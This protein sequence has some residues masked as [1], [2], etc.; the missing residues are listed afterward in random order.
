MTL[1]VIYVVEWR[2]ED[3]GRFGR[4]DSIS[5][6]TLADVTASADNLGVFIGYGQSNSDCCGSSGYVLSHPTNL[7]QFSIGEH[8]SNQTWRYREPMLGAFCGG[9]CPYGPI[10]DELITNGSYAQV[11]FATAGMPG[12]SIDMLNRNH[13]ASHTYFEYLVQT[14]RA[15]FR[16]YGKIDGILFHQ[17]ESDV[18]RSSAYEASFRTL[19]T[20]LENALQ[21]L[22]DNGHEIVVFVSRASYCAGN[23]DADLVD[24]Q[25][26]LPSV[27]DGAATGPNTDEL[28]G[29][30]FRYDDC[31]FTVE[32]L[33]HIGKR[34]L[35]YLII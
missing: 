31:H 8:A 23:A 30:L 2:K 11:V 1:A 16:T 17:G 33:R 4:N 21:D 24:V 34:W 13:D 6:L 20:N 25:T 9:G 19:M 18:G 5:D 7:F 29:G 26:R 27:V 12:A 10:G 28:Q 32:G 35:G 3:S 22:L 14:Y 15:M